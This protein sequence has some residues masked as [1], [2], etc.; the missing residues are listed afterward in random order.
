MIAIRPGSSCART[1]VARPRLG[2]VL[3]AALLLAPAF[4]P[5]AAALDGPPVARPTPQQAAWQDCEL[6]M[7]IH[8]SMNT[9][10]DQEYDDLSLPLERFNPAELNTDEWV[11]VAEAMDARYIVFVAKH[12]GGF[13]LWPTDT[14]DYS[15][16][17]TPWRDGKGNVLADLAES[18]R[19]RNMRLGIYISPTDRKQGA[20]GGGKCD[21][22]EAQEKYDRIYRTQL[23]EALGTVRRILEPIHGDGAVF[24]VWFDGSIVVP[25][26]D[27]LERLAPR[28]MVF[29]GPH[30]TLRWVGN[31]DGVAPYPAWNSVPLDAARAGVATAEHG[32][33]DGDAWLPNECDARM[34][35]TWFW[36]TRNAGA[37]KSV[38]QLME[39]Y[40]RSVGHG[41]VLLLNQTPDTS[42]RIP[43]ADAERGREFA[44][45]VRRRYGK[46]IARS[47]ELRSGECELRLPAGARIARLVTMEEIAQGERIREYV[48]EGFADGAWKEIGRG[49][50]VGHKKID[51][52]APGVLERIRLRVT[53]SAGEVALREFAAFE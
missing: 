39:M 33:P 48:L 37:L 41:A 29:Q 27:I 15:V 43:A 46:S 30:A 3:L 53:Q 34:R 42:G 31:E 50:A 1:R 40:E 20:G 13:C 10:T 16:R 47:S 18:C 22:P 24:E 11:A 4:S 52:V 7:F 17:S 45:E 32:R 9:F 49:S 5:T 26:G 19:T 35:N 36:N 23:E 44:A 14:T 6:G 2:R 25:V 21:T 12:A 28:A 51:R 8:F 38:E